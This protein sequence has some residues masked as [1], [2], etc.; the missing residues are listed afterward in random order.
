MKPKVFATIFV[1]V[2]C[3]GAL[4]FALVQMQTFAGL[5]NDAGVI[6]G[7]TQQAVKLALADQSNETIVERVDTLVSKLEREESERLIKD[8]ASREF[9][10]DIETVKGTWEL[11]NREF[12]ALAQGSGSKARLLELSEE[13][14]READAMVL[15]A[16]H[17]AERDLL[18]TIVGCLLLVIAVTSAVALRERRYQRARERALETDPLTKGPNLLAFER[19][20]RTQALLAPPG[21]YLIVYTNVENFRVINESFGRAAGDE[22]IRAL[23][24]LFKRACSHEEF[25]AHANA[26]HFALLLRNA[27]NRAEQ[28]AAQVQARL[29]AD[30]QL[31]FSDRIT[32]G[33]GVYEL[34]D[35]TEDIAVAVSNASAVLKAGVGSDLIARYDDAFRS[36]LA[37]EQNVVRLMADALEGE[38]FLCYLQAQNSLADGHVVGAEMLCRWQSPELGFLSPDRFIPQFERN[39]FISELDFYMLE[40]ACRRYREL[41]N[42][43]SEG[44]P[45]HLSVNV[46]RVTLLQNGFE[47]RFMRLIDRYG[48]PH[49][50]LHVEVTEGVFSVET[51]AVIGILENLQRSGFP[52]AMDDF[53]S[54]YS[55]LALLKAMPIDVIKIDRCFLS[56]SQDDARARRILEGVMNL[57][58]DLGIATVC[59]GIET[60]EQAELLRNL[61]CEI[62]QGYYFA[63]PVPFDELVEQLHAEQAR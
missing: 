11:I 48:M 27:P 63:R 25:V 1:W 10:Q 39:G 14:F 54:G 40:Q 13:H 12:D 37:F 3:V 2:I 62:A 61:G 50:R 34:A 7:G 5:I 32:C 22:A 29:K 9:F 60:K 58:K 28:M 30:D 53:G 55:S 18:W 47:E 15:S 26:D 19:R 31:P 6:R 46:S 38:E 56:A 42:P 51:D 8:E 17:R 21:T 35:R 36:K 59:E 41:D 57:A 16:Q 43:A 44:R 49:S 4:A 52:I 23:D 45:L 33:Y 24:E 20:T